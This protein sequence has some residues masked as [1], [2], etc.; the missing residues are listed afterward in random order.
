MV[1]RES[2]G[3]K[4][5]ALVI[6][7]GVYKFSDSMPVLAN[8]AND[9]E[10]IAAALRGFGFEVIERK[11]QTK[12]EMDTAIYEF[13]RKIG[14]SE[15]ALFYYAGHGLQIK[16]QN[17][18][19][20]V[21]AKIESEAQVPYKSVNL[22]QLLDEMENGKSRANIVMLDACR[23]N[24]LTGKFRSGAT[25]GLAAP[26]SA[27]KGT[28]IVY[29]TDPGGVAADG[30]GRNGLFTAGLLAA[31]KGKDLSLGG[32]LTRASEEVE[33]GSERRQ[34][35]YINGPATLQKNFHFA[36]GSVAVAGAE[37]ESEP[38]EAAEPPSSPAPVREDAETVLWNEV[39]K[40]NTA[41]DYDAYLA[42]FPKGKYSALAK[43]RVQKLQE[44]TAAETRSRLIKE[45]DEARSTLSAAEAGDVDAMEKMTRYYDAGIG[46]AKDPAKAA[47]WRDKIESIA[48]REQLRVA[49]SGNIQAMLKVAARYDAG[50]G[51]KKDPAQAQA[52][53]AKADAAIASEAAQEKERIK[54]RK[55][56]QVSFLGETKR[57][58][59]ENEAANQNNPSSITAVPSTVVSGLVGDMVSAPFRT[60]EIAMIKNEAAYRPSTWAK[61]DS[62]IARAS[63]RQHTDGSTTENYL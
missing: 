35:P 7:N 28:V 21:D 47:K 59:K 40:G 25:R 51:L 41:E 9:A 11:N 62:M 60:T 38:V 30:D 26:T 19:V 55:V 45:A 43:R 3:G 18:L 29:A 24:P 61:S 16:G 6:G 31:F 23:N 2:A 49:Q 53:R 33:Q 15:A 63:R 36:P 56:D 22:N 4:R 46:V 10:D 13:G 58:L 57:L 8:P 17:F 1:K 44:Q 20:P 48:A 27:P 12:E 5:V 54:E 52:W 14:D 34:T 32:V 39:Q 50:L 37:L 42:K